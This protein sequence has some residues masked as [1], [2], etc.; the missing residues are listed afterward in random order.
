MDL[1]VVLVV[2]VSYSTDKTGC[3]LL[4]SHTYS[5]LLQLATEQRKQEEQRQRSEQQHAARMQQARPVRRFAPRVV[6][7]K[8]NKR[9]NYE[10]QDEKAQSK[11]NLDG[12][13]K[14]VINGFCLLVY[15]FRVFAR[16][17]TRDQKILMAFKKPLF[18]VFAHHDV[19]P[20]RPR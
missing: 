14:C 5:R 4:C 1:L 12:E 20:R 7:G 15:T 3:T 16:R 17:R 10:Q 6:Y 8:T 13:R 2:V 11:N 19:R 9:N 18:L